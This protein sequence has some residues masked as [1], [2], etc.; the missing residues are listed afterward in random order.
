MHRTRSALPAILT[1]LTLG[2]SGGGNRADAGPT[3]TCGAGTRLS[4]TTC[5]LDSVDAGPAPTCG[6]GTHLAFGAC[7]G[8]PV[9]A[10]AIPNRDGGFT[11]PSSWAA[12]TQISHDGARAGGE[13]Q[14]AVDSHGTIYLA[15]MDVTSP[16]LGCCVYLVRSPA[17]PRG[18]V[19]VDR[20]ESTSAGIAYGAP[21]V[22]VD[23]TDRVFFGFA[24]YARGSSGR[25]SGSV[26]V[27]QS[28][29]GLTFDAP[30]EAGTHDVRFPS[31][32]RPWLTV[33]PDASMHVSWA[34][35]S[36]SYA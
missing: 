10:G 6:P 14:L 24:R 18:F 23:R 29:D 32:D 22:A 26:L 19:Q 35:S 9:D 8:D 21:T 11:D 34:Y 33:A 12:N 13:P 1:L 27:A 28:A 5:V 25:S 3:L 36:L 16:A 7:V 30:Q 2:C 20:V 31:N 4:G 15:Y 17:S